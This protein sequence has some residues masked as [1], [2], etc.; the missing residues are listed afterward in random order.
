MWRNEAE[1]MKAKPLLVGNPMGTALHELAITEGIWSRSD[2]SAGATDILSLTHPHLVQKLYE[3]YLSAEVDILVTNTF[4]S[5]AKWIS[6]PALAEKIY[7][8][9]LR[10][11]QDLIDSVPHQAE[12]AVSVGPL[13][14]ENISPTRIS[15]AFE[16]MAETTL[17]EGA[18][19][20][21]IETSLSATATL[22]AIKS[23]QK[24]AARE[25]FSPKIHV[26]FTPNSFGL[27]IDGMNMAEA[28]RKTEEA[29][30]TTVGLN[31]IFPPERGRNLLLKAAETTKLPLSYRPSISFPGE[32]SISAQALAKLFSLLLQSGRMGLVGPCCGG[33][34]AHLIALRNII[35]ATENPLS[36]HNL[37]T[38]IKK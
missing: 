20:F 9:S 37:S 36:T 14:A 23:I 17:N 12:I 7:R 29:G 15:E 34:K 38:L 30:A 1:T 5:T 25:G 26:E 31:C 35:K 24:V 3:I 32:K 27:T 4:A 11:A 13:P 2:G 6:Q 8:Q 28:F 21:L 16:Q 19:R 18:N 22:S 10:I 33:Q